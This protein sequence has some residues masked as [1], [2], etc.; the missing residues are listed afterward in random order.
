LPNYE[1]G[2]D[3]NFISSDD[4]TPEESDFTDLSIPGSSVEDSGG[5][6]ESD[7]SLA[8][9]LTTGGLDFGS[10]LATNVADKT[11]KDILSK[12]TDK[13]VTNV[14]KGHK[15]SG[16][17]SKTSAIVGESVGTV[18]SFIALDDVDAPF[19]GDDEFGTDDISALAGGVEK[20]ATLTEK[21]ITVGQNLTTKGILTG[22][23][24]S[25]NVTDLVKASSAASKAGNVASIAGTVSGGA[26]IVGDLIKYADEG[27]GETYEEAVGNLASTTASGLSLGT[28]IA[29][30]TG[31]SGA[32]ATAF[33][34]GAAA[35]A[36]AGG[37]A[38][39]G[40]AAGTATATA[41]SVAT[42]AAAFGPVGWAIA[43]LT[44]LGM[45]LGLM[46]EF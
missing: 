14:V 10:K 34:G 33:G 44:I 8:A 24:G 30:M 28:G 1:E 29:A 21:G 2:G 46:D 16:A 3:K 22:A 25:K 35:G 38:A 15:T 18:G 37:A 6:E 7:V 27:V 41:T 17:L 13:D 20:A 5:D 32:F 43:G 31:S 12:S 36:A 11:A 19:Q 45:G 9:D 26:N 39:G 40:A 23:K 4:F 42:G